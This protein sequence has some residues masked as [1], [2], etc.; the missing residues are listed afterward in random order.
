MFCVSSYY[1]FAGYGDF[2]GNPL[3][4]RWFWNTR[5]RLRYLDHI[6]F[7]VSLYL[8]PYCR[9]KAIELCRAGTRSSKLL[10]RCDRARRAIQ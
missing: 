3:D 9:V 10:V 7:M 1:N 4:Q 2:D 5:G 6:V 8:I